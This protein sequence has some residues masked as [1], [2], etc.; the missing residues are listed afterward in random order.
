M[1]KTVVLFCVAGLG[2]S[3]ALIALKETAGSKVS[4][5]ANELQYFGPL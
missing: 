2:L 1:R 3:L 5:L 4:Q